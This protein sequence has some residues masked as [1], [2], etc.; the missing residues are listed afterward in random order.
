M[1]ATELCVI[2]PGALSASCWARLASHLPA[3]TPVK[4]LELETVNR[5]W[6]A[7]PSLTVAA[8]AERLR[9][10]LGATRAPRVLVGWGV[11]GAVADALAAPARRVVLL[12]APAPGL[13]A[14][15]PDEQQRLR[16]FA[17]YVG[18]RKGLSVVAPELAL[19]GIREAAI[20]AG[21]LRA[22]TTPE[23]LERCFEEHSAR[24][25]RDH[26]LIAGHTPS[27]IPLT[28]VK[29]AA[30]LVPDSPALGWDRYG[31]VERLGSGG[32]HYS[33]LTD[34]SAATHLAM[35]LRRWLTP[36]YAATT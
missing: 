32:D 5:F 7:D 31:P 16:S 9:G 36:G 8:L 18:A 28:V 19:E 33:M 12:D 2:H 24:V 27:G 17:M 4:V 26:R 34:R 6:A 13:L 10:R 30:S 22:D 21:A 29:A 35:L 25:L 1:P 20:A 23:A 15:E 3:G 11:G 14:G